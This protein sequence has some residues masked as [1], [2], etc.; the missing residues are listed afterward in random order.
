[1]GHLSD[2]QLFA[3]MARRRLAQ[4]A[5]LEDIELSAEEAGHHLGEDIQAATIESLGPEDTKPKPCP[6]CGKRAPVKARNRVRH[7]LTVAGELRISRNYHHCR[8][9]KR[10][11]YPRD[12]ALELPE[13]GEV[14]DAME[15]RILDFGV[16]TSFKEAAQR[17]AIHYPTPISSNLVRRVV[18][19]VGRRAQAA[20][21]ALSLQK[22]CRP[23][24]EQ[25]PQTL[26]VAGDGSMLGTREGW[27]EAKVAVVAPGD[28]V[29]P[30]KRRRTDAQ[31]RYVA[32]LGN[33]EEFRTAL[34]A[35]LD[36]ELA[37]DV[38]HIIWL[39]D[40]AKENWTMASELCPF[41][42]Q[43]LDF[44]HAIQN[45]MTCAK[46]LLGEG[47][48]GL[49]IWEARIRQLLLGSSPEAVICELMDCLSLTTTD[50]HLEALN[51]LVGYYRANIKRMRYAEFL[52]Q[53]LPIG[54]GLVESAHKHVLQVRMKQA[55]QRWSILRGRRMVE[56]R[57]LYRTAGPRRF[58]WAI[59][60]ALQVPPARP[61]SPLQ[62]A[63]RRIQRRYVLARGSSLN[64][65]AL[66]A[67]I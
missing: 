20:H 13:E 24:P 6:K 44:M 38:M 67:S 46:V 56:L 40:G 12:I 4:G 55:G 59:R 50:E 54:S 65:A 8:A 47:D 39:G 32:V 25:P 66:A 53:G 52:E 9:C 23:S 36:A 1:M 51:R 43:I 26:V 2:A 17:W 42:I 30:D 7:F 49:P 60:Q 3:E 31:A 19:R 33:Q 35:A 5:T 29:I 57:A 48:A 10:G 45:A 28:S 14:S 11:F 63:P 61:N 41:A 64:R 22:A 21:S 34:K 27:K 62:N 16:N 58:H 15:R 37:D 18:D